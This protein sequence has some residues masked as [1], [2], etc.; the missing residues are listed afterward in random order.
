MSRFNGPGSP[1]RAGSRLLVAVAALCLVA[2]SCGGD[3][4]DDEATADTG[5]TATTSGAAAPTGE[6]IKVM[7]MA[8]VNTDVPPYPNIPAAAEVYEQWIND[9]GGI[10]GRPL[11]VTTCDTRGDVNEGAAC[12]RRAVEEGMVAVVGSFTFEPAASSPCWRR[13][14]SPGSAPVAR[15]SSRSSRAPI[16][17]CSAACS[18]PKGSAPSSRWSRTAVRTSS[19]STWTSP[20]PTSG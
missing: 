8:P 4:S 11:E 3:D 12:A 15:S 2:V 18:P 7:T 10:N 14:A 17:S 20:P 5:A 6:P 9:Q 1:Q 16:L 19:S 13:A